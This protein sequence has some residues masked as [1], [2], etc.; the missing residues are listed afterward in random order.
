MVA[1]LTDPIEEPMLRAVTADLQ[2]DASLAAQYRELLLRPQLSAISTRLEQAGAPAA[3]DVA[4]MFVGPIFYRWLLRS[5]P[6]NPEWIRAHVKR[7]IRTV[8]P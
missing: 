1:Q 7:V 5:E 6:F 8:E 3:D 2:S 4:E